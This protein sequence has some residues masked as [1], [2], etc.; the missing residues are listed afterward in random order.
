[1]S[2]L[3]GMKA[4]LALIVV[5][6]TALSWGRNPLVQASVEGLIDRA[7]SAARSGRYVEA[8]ACVEAVV[9]K[10]ELRVRVDRSGLSVDEKWVS[11]RALERAVQ[12]W[13]AVLGNEVFIRFVAEG[14]AD[15]RIRYAKDVYH[16]GREAAGTAVWSRRVDAWGDGRFTSRVSADIVLRTERPGGGAM[17]EDAMVHAALHELGHVFGLGDTAKVGEAM[18]PLRLA[19]PA[20][21]LTKREIAAIDEV[22]SAAWV[23]W[24]ACLTSGWPGQRVT[25]RP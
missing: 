22:R 2:S 20:T 16:L 18:G 14:P 6:M 4:G 7:E 1:M 21:R 5:G 25:S 8:M 12:E 3:A 23:V 24:E 15:V 13:R 9:L 11:A 17:G 10:P 19:R